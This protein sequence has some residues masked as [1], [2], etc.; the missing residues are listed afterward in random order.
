MKKL[1]ILLITFL[2]MSITYVQAKAAE[3]DVHGEFYV[4]GE[5]SDA[6][7]LAETNLSPYNEAK[8]ENEFNVWQRIRFALDIV[9]SE[10]LSAHIHFRAPSDGLWGAE[11]LGVGGGDYEFDLKRAYIDWFMPFTVGGATLEMRMGKQLYYYGSTFGS[12][13]IYD[14]ASGVVALFDFGNVHW[15]ENSGGHFKMSMQWMRAFDLQTSPIA[16][17][18]TE[19]IDLFALEA[20]YTNDDFTFNPWVVYAVGGDNLADA[21]YENSTFGA[22]NANSTLLGE[23]NFWVGFSSQLHMYDPLTLSLGFTY[24]FADNIYGITNKD[25]KTNGWL[26]DAEL[27][28]HTRYG[29]PSLIGWYASGD[30]NDS[31]Q[32]IPYLSPGW[33]P[34]TSAFFSDALALAPTA[35]VSS[36]TGTWAVGIKWTGF[37]PM[38][39]VEMGASVLYV[40]GTNDV[41]I[42]DNSEFNPAYMTTSDA[43]V[44]LTAYSNY[45]IYKDLQAQ[46]EVNYLIAD[47]DDSYSSSSNGIRVALGFFYTF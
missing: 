30:D 46:I 36:P 32:R 20:T 45:D 24:S 12:P 35:S 25:D 11:P 42:I 37:E 29:T 15:F 14:D 23:N 21:V 7:G 5:Y 43:L 19:N 1:F 44:E 47:I 33:N 8:N 31:I 3:I 40:A 39:K 10:T 27:A 26:I 16:N 28:Y 34:T 9:S 13:I 22:S 2:F 18:K 41:D 17:S 6:L 4:I 38:E